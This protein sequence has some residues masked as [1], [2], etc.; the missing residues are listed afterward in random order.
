MGRFR[1]AIIL[2]TAAVV[3]LGVTAVP[4]QATR[5]LRV[6]ASVST[7][8]PEQYATVTAK[9]KARDQYGKAISGAKCVFMWYYKTT[10]PVVTKYTSSTGIASCPRFISRA[11]VGYKVVIRI[12]CTWKG[13]V[14]SCSTWFIPQ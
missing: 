13:Q 5:L 1:Y 4:A 9:A 11:T 7:H 14:K 2:M 8:Y 3:L 6:S 10:T 12:R